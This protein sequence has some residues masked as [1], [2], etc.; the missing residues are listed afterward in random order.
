MPDTWT[1][2]L[3]LYLDGELSGPETK[4]LESHLYTCPA[5][6]AGLFDR[7]RLRRGLQIAAR[8]Y[9]PSTSLRK[10]VG[11]LTERRTWPSFSWVWVTAAVLPLVLIVWS[12]GFFSRSRNEQRYVFSEVAD[13]HVANFAGGSPVDVVSSDRHTVK[14]WFEGKV[15]FA[16]SL[17]ELQGSDFT[18]LGG[19]V[20][21]LGQTPGAHLV[22]KLRKHQISVFIFQEKLP[23]MPS[24]A[25]PVV[26]SSFDM[27]TWT[28]GGLRYFV[29]GDT[30][31]NDIQKLA[32]LLK[33]AANS[34]ETAESTN[35]GKISC[36]QAS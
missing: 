18:L 2:K 36:P 32:A 24:D 4:D 19:R 10:Q 21:Y 29:V 31:P 16:I 15:P 8:R 1:P 12:V 33:A 5:C 7:V 11:R 23:G 35:I 13:L 14:P 26:R 20:T 22:Y 9:A 28:N 34:S 25:K 27:E 3:D 17:P 30:G 6:A